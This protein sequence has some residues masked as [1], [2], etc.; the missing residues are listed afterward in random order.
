M[1]P[2][3]VFISSQTYVGNL[4]GVAGADQ[5]CQ[6]LAS[7]AGLSG[8]YKA[9]LSDANNR[10]PATGWK[11][12][13]GPFRLRNG[14]TVANN[15]NEIITTG[16]LLNPISLDEYGRP[17]A[18]PSYDPYGKIY[19]WTGTKAALTTSQSI[20][21]STPSQLCNNWNVSECMY[22]T[23]DQHSSCFGYY[24]VVISQTQTYTQQYWVDANGVRYCGSPCHL[25]CFQQ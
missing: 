3:T 19:V 5:L 1:V 14:V 2:K 24:G 15:W 23:A 16:R 22:S 11:P 7:A 17:L 6:R 13:S 8:T 9:W 25:Y 4:G 18:P 10:T 21:W 12:S 20:V